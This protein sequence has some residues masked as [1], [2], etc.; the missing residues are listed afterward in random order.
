MSNESIKMMLLGIMIML[1]G[2]FIMLEPSGRWEG[3]GVFTLLIGL[4]IGIL[5][6]IKK[7]K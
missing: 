5:E 6:V 7:E 4:A 2:G 3:V 1:F